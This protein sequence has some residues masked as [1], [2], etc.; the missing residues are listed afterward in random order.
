M[1]YS[2]RIFAFLSIVTMLCACAAQTGDQTAQAA[3]KQIQGNAQSTSRGGSCEPSDLVC[4]KSSLYGGELEG[5]HDVRRIWERDGRYSFYIDV[6]H[7]VN[8]GKIK[9]IQRYN[10]RPD[11]VC[12]HDDGGSGLL[13]CFGLARSDSGKP[14]CA[15]TLHLWHNPHQ[16]KDGS[17]NYRLGATG[18]DA[19]NNGFV[20]KSNGVAI[21][22]RAHQ[23]G[24]VSTGSYRTDCD[25]LRYASNWE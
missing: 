8:T 11:R 2:V 25:A 6:R 15:H 16:P 10:L 23:L 14:Y 24:A 18:I 19:H 4:D 7:N 12:G 17:L 21:H 1:Q 22:P 3:S 13:L 20:G 9:T 5:Q